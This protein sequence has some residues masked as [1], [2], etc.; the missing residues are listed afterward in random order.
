MVHRLFI[1]F[2]QIYV[3]DA[4]SRTLP[5]TRFCTDGD[6]QEVVGKRVKSSK[7][8]SRASAIGAVVTPRDVREEENSRFL[9]FFPKIPVHISK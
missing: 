8:Y 3:E 6:E 1:I 2:E 7:V 4:N 9:L 5:A